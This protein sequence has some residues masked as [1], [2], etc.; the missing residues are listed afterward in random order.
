MPKG[1]Q[2]PTQAAKAKDAFMRDALLGR[3][4]RVLDEDYRLPEQRYAADF[5]PDQPRD[6]SGKWSSGESGGDDDIRAMA[7]KLAPER[8]GVSENAATYG[9]AV[10]AKASHAF[11]TSGPVKRGIAQVIGSVALSTTASVAHETTMHLLKQGTE[12]ALDGAI[13]MVGSHLLGSAGLVAAGSA[14]SAIAPVAIAVVAGVAVH[15]LAE[16]A[17]VTDENAR[18]VLAATGRFL[19]THFHALATARES[20]PMAGM[21]DADEGDD[22]VLRSL[23]LLVPYWEEDQA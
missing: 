12:V 18:K 16:H 21:V 23:D 15:K 14:A 5:S 6:E 20:N 2:L 11:I 10:A 22:I 4:A 3:I 17:G 1:A 19:I 13:T 7:R 8:G 9:I